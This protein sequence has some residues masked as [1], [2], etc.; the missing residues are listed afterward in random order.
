MIGIVLVLARSSLALSLCRCYLEVY[1]RYGFPFICI[2]LCGVDCFTR[3]TCPSFYGV[4]VDCST[5]I[6]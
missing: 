6:M 2:L 5:F 4:Y 3:V 1:A